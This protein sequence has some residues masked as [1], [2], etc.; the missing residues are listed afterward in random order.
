M[1]N[2]DLWPLIW[3][4]LDSLTAHYGPAIDH[5]AEELGIPLGEWYGWVMAAPL[6]EPQPVSARLLHVRAAFTNPVKLDADLAR[7]VQLGLLEPGPA[8]EYRLTEKGQAG[9]EHLIQT[10]WT[11]MNKLSP[12]PQA[13]LLRLADLLKRVDDGCLAAPEPPDKWCLRIERHYDPGVDA[14]VMPRLDQY[15]SD[16]V[17]YRDDARIAV[18]ES[19]GVS[20]QAWEASGLLWR[21]VAMTLDELCERL[22]RRGWSREDYKA[23]VQELIDRGWVTGDEAEYVV[24]DLGRA[25]REEA[26][27]RRDDYFHRPFGCL[28]EDEL[29]ELEQLLTRLCDVLEPVAA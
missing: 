11:A 10:A 2:L 12:L 9:V 7:G 13:D 19:Y 22:A 27:D 20:G 17:A 16:L 1:N 4:T 3:K 25:V 23:A 14:P 21:G 8:G 26:K 29:D 5:A 24:T 6:F 15:L 28:D 18:R